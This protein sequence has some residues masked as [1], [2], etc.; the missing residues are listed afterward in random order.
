MVE[1][2][3]NEQEILLI[4]LTF[5]FCLAQIA[6]CK[7]TFAPYQYLSFEAMTLESEGA[8][9]S[10]KSEMV[11]FFYDTAFMSEDIVLKEL[12]FGIKLC[13]EYRPDQLQ[14][15]YINKKGRL[16]INYEGLYHV[17]H[18]DDV[19]K[20]NKALTNNNFMCVDV[21]SQFLVVENK[22]TKLRVLSEAFI[23]Q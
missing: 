9:I 22:T 7:P 17:M 1:I 2:S 4:D 8:Q 6:V 12:N 16:N 18:P 3:K 14:K 21:E 13:L 10:G 20:Y 23:I 11:Y 19:K 5:E 15:M